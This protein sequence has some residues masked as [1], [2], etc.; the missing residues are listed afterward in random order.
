MP[1]GLIGTGPSA[2]P[3]TGT[4][5]LN[6]LRDQAAPDVGLN[7]EL[8]KQRSFFQTLIARDK[9]AAERQGLLN[10][11]AQFAG[12]RNGF[13]SALG[14]GGSAFENTVQQAALAEAE[15]EQEAVLRQQQEEQAEFQRQLQLSQQGNAERRLG[16]QDRSLDLQEAR[17]AANARNGGGSGSRDKFS[18]PQLLRDAQGRLVAVQGSSGGGIRQTPI[19]N[20]QPFNNSAIGKADAKFVEE[21]RERRQAATVQSDQASD[22]ISIL[23]NIPDDVAFGSLSGARL[24]TDKLLQSAGITNEQR[25]NRVK[26]AEAIKSLE[27]QQFVANSG[28]LKGALSNQ[29]GERINR[30]GATLGDSKE[31]ALFKARLIQFQAKRAEEREDF[32]ASAVREQGLSPEAARRAYDSSLE[33]QDDPELEALVSQFERPSPSASDGN[34][35][36]PGFDGLSFTVENN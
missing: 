16:Q 6:R 29:E 21:A 14:S 10:A 9:T 20:L 22:A 11:A 31:G 32:V 13:A 15:A 12:G 23:E 5:A 7:P 27:N 19:G 18:A 1:L 36:V 3:V 24:S 28:P 34:L 2:A 26:A 4:A 25:D 30:I 17:D 8:P 35:P 33:D